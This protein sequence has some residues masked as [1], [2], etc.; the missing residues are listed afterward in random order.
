MPIEIG[1]AIRYNK[2]ASCISRGSEFRTYVGVPG[3]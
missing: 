3:A 2:E 1:D